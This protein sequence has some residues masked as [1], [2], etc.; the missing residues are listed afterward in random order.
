[1]LEDLESWGKTFQRQGWNLSVCYKRGVWRCLLQN[2]EVAMS[3]IKQY[4]S[5]PKEAMAGASKQLEA[6]SIKG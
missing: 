2:S 3:P 1:M 5:T 4:G 6:L